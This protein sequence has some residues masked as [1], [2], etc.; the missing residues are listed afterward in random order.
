[1]YSSEVHAVLQST[2]LKAMEALKA[3][4]TYFKKCT[5]KTYLKTDLS[6]PKSMGCR[7]IKCN[8]IVQDLS[9]QALNGLK[10]VLRPTVIP[11]TLCSRSKQQ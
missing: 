5:L 1:M 9:G 4:K 10:L 8:I 6:I 11:L 3:I 7:Y 2:A